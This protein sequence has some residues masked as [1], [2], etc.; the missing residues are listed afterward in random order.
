MPFRRTALNQRHAQIG[1]MPKGSFS[2]KRRSRHLSAPNH[3]SQIASDLKS[4]IPNRKNFPQIA[5]LDSSNRTFKSRD[6]WFEPLFKSPLES[7]C[8]IPVQQVRT[9]GFSEKV[10]TVIKSRDLE[11]LGGQESPRQTKPKKGPKRKAHEF[12]PFFVNSG[13]FFLRKRSTI[14]IELLFRNAPVK[15]SWTDL[16]L[17]WFS[18]GHSLITAF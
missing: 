6:L 15:S 3:K 9:L 12:R 8:R 2:P 4:R 7:Q 14:H 16:S 1:H 11:H 17:V 13:V 5:V 18:P 10:L